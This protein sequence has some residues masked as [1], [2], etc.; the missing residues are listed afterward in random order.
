[1]CDFIQFINKINPEKYE[2]TYTVREDGYCICNSTDKEV[3]RFIVDKFDLSFDETLIIKRTPFSW[4]V[5][6]KKEVG[7]E[8]RST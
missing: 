5:I 2:E 7:N 4:K 6:Y 8:P 1:M 3:M